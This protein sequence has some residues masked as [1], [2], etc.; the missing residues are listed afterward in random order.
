M[1]DAVYATYM[2]G[3]VILFGKETDNLNGIQQIYSK[4]NKLGMIK[5]S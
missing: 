3:V 2:R 1:Y 4:G 5:Y